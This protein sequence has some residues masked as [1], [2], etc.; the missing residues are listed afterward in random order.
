MPN[1]E[2][3]RRA[4]SGLP[5]D[6]SGGPTIDPT[7]NVLDLVAAETRRHDDL[8]HAEGRRQDDLRIAERL[9]HEAERRHISEMAAV[10]DSCSTEKAVMREHHS[11]EMRIAE[12]E[13]LDATRQQDQIAVN[14]AADRAQVAIKAVADTMAQTFNSIIARI[15]ALERTSY[16]GEGKSAGLSM[17]WAVILGVVT[18]VSGLLGIGGIV[19]AVYSK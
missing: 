6:P 9:L 13:R 16:S 14:T 10:R 2:E 18:L 17:S 4:P 15:A 3:L 5:V 1:R 8:R 7:K 11:K 12:K 19:F